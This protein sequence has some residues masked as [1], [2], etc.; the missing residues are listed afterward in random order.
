MSLWIISSL[1]VV[2]TI[3]IQIDST[4]AD[5]KIKDRVDILTDK[6]DNMTGIIEKMADVVERLNNKVGVGHFYS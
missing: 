6:I 5:H 1:V 2:L 3:G 4:V